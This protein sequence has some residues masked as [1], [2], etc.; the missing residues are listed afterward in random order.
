MQEDNKE[1]AREM[2]SC[3]ESIDIIRVDNEQALVS[4]DVFAKVQSTWVRV[5]G[6]VWNGPR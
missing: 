6:K 2:C 5:Q 4:M 1:C 3:W